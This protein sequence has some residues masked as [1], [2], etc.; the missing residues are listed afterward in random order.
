MTRTLQPG[1]GRGR[2]H[3]GAVWQGPGA[4]SL[5]SEEAGPWKVG[6]L[7]RRTG[8]SI[9]TLHWYDQ[10]GL[11]RPSQRTASGHRLYDP[12]DVQRLQQIRS[13]RHLGFTLEEVRDCLRRGRFTP[14]KVLRLHL[15]ELREQIQRQRHLAGRLE[16]LADRLDAAGAVSVDELMTI[17]EEITMSESYLTPEQLAEV[18]ARGRMLGEAHI[19]AVEAEWPVLIANVRGEMEKS[20][21]ASDP[22]VQALARRW[23]ELVNEFTGGN[24]GIEKALAQNYQQNPEARRS[25]GLD[26]EIFAYVQR[27]WAA[28]PPQ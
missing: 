6:D 18:Q 9:R 7:A 23:R 19:Q 11:L 24:P 10:L 27:A 16:R 26:G 4:R 13:L 12:A 1:P 8:L 28:A 5:R 15:A 21:P 2:G 17:I 22:R 3:P 25:T 20:T 14:A